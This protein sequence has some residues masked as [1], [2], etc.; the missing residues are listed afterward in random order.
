MRHGAG[1]TRVGRERRS[2]G[3]RLRRPRCTLPANRREH[4]PR[5]VT[6]IEIVPIERPAAPPAE[7]LEV[8]IVDDPPV[9]PDAPRAAVL[10]TDQ[11]DSRAI[12]W[13]Q[14]PGDPP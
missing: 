14:L 7:P 11:A 13:P 2:P 5:T 6:Q 1:P 10:T 12:V 8:A 4:A 9:K 3:A